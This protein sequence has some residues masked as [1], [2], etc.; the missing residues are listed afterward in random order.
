MEII[1]VKPEDKTK[2]V[3][4]GAVMQMFAANAAKA[5]GKIQ[6]A[7]VEI[8][9]Y[10]EAR[11]HYYELLKEKTDLNDFKEYVKAIRYV[12]RKLDEIEIKKD[13]YVYA[14]DWSY[15][16]VDIGVLLKN[17][18]WNSEK[19][20]ETLADTKIDF[21]IEMK[22]IE[23]FQEKKNY[24]NKK[25]LNYYDPDDVRDL[26][27]EKAY[28]DIEDKNI[29][30]ANV[31]KNIYPRS[32]DSRWCIYDKEKNTLTLFI[33]FII[34][35]NRTIKSNFYRLKR[36]R[37]NSLVSGNNVSDITAYITNQLLHFDECPIDYCYND[38]VINM[39]MNSR[40]WQTIKK[41]L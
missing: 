23:T 19:C 37:Y 31:G 7:I 36:S 9:E 13:L 10:R 11:Q 35:S 14:A 28:W 26:K 17:D 34:V 3:K 33:Y 40:C 20:G 1:K 4:N 29:G 41:M 30:N 27:Y 2:I 24:T 8:R 21:Y 32:N 15:D 6:N 12:I 16:C 38:D 18:M 25:K 22:Y 39:R 5:I